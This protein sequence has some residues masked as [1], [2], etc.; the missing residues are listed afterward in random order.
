MGIRAIE[1][2]SRMKLVINEHYRILSCLEEGNSKKA[3]KELMKHL[4][5]TE[6][7]LI[8]NLEKEE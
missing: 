3:Y 5:N 6:R 1:D 8:E 2:H 7:V 4:D